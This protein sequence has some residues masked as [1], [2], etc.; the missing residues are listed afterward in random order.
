MY[1][2]WD[3]MFCK[4]DG[5]SSM[6]FFIY[7]SDYYYPSGDTYYTLPEA[8]AAFEKLKEQRKGEMEFDRDPYFETDYLCIVLDE[9]DKEK[10]KL[11][12]ATF[13]PDED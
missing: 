11:E 6:K 8:L 13:V 1:F 4:R 7:G 12:M 5:E 2:L 9:I 3:E 10:M